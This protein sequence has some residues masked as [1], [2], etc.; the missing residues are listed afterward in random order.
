M[1]Q[2]IDTSNNSLVAIWDTLPA[3]FEAPGIGTIS[4]AAPGWTSGT[5]VLVDTTP[6]PPPIIPTAQMLARLAADKRY[7]IETSGF[8]AA[9]IGP[10]ATDRDSQSKLL[11]EM[12][13]MGAGLRA[14]PSGWKLRDGTFAMLSNA[15]MMTVIMAARAH[16][17]TA[18]G[19]EAALVAGITA[20]TVATLADIDAANWPAIS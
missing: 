9:G 10:I 14:D 17:A 11:A 20:G 6:P 1:I 4:N 19:V 13:A 5:L 15:N 18:F 8:V 16:I 2:L 12:V 7:Q 3:T